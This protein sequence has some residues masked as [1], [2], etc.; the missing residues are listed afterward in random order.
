MMRYM[1]LAGF[2]RPL[3]R[4]YFEEVQFSDRT[5]PSASCFFNF[6]LDPSIH[7]VFFLVWTTNP[8][9]ALE[10]DL[11]LNTLSNL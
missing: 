6:A 10:A 3:S 4:Y 9:T 2:A 8:P 11:S 7:K 1:Y 5:R